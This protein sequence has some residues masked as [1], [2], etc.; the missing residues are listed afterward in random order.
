MKRRW[1]SLLLVALLFALLAMTAAI[2]E[3]NDE[4]ELVINDEELVLFSEPSFLDIPE[5]IELSL[6]E[7]ELPEIEEIGEIML[8]TSLDSMEPTTDPVSS[9][10]VSNSNP[11]DFEIINLAK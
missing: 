9:A 3:T 2:A 5:E 8:D 7:S 4:I 6:G 11:D 1:I 10:A